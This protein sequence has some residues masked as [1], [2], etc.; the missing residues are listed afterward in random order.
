MSYYSLVVVVWTIVRLADGHGRIILPAGR[1]TAWRYNYPTEPNYD[2]NQLFCGGAAVQHETNS[3][4][5]GVCG[6]DWR[7]KVPRENEHGGKYGQGVIVQ[8]YRL[9]N[10]MKIQIEITAPHMGWYEFTLCDTD[11]DEQPADLDC[12]NRNVL[13]GSQNKTAVTL[14]IRSRKQLRDTIISSVQSEREALENLLITNDELETKKFK[15][16][17]PGG[18][19]NG[20]FTYYLILPLGLTCDNCVLR[21]KYFCGNSWG[22]E[23]DEKLNKERCCIGCGDKQ[24]QFYG[25]ADIAILA[26]NDDRQLATLPSKTPIIQAGSPSSNT[27]KIVEELVK[28]KYYGAGDGLTCRPIFKYHDIQSVHNVCSQIT[29]NACECLVKSNKKKEDDGTSPESTTT[30]DKTLQGDITSKQTDLYNNDEQM[31]L[32]ERLII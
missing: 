1:S 25:C 16:K 24:E 29:T 18:N 7:A 10:M 28:D 26:P 11:T 32:N 27:N 20:I 5:C 8:Q 12:F 3:G 14:Y 9:E 22:C 15:N 21:W 19:V 17:F 6:D 4:R 2:D 31:N 13:R 30:T 23:L